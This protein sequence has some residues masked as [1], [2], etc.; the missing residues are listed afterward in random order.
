MCAFDLF[1]GLSDWFQTNTIENGPGV[2]IFSQEEK[3]NTH[4]HTVRRNESNAYV[5]GN[6]IEYDFEHHEISWQTF[7][8]PL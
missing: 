7:T 4:T 8:H 6:R 5:H 2:K 1:C 3:K